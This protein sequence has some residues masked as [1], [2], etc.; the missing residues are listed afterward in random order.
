MSYNAIT[1]SAA[2]KSDI[3]EVAS[4]CSQKV[5]TNYVMN[6]NG[7]YGI[8]VVEHRERLMC[9]NSRNVFQYKAA[10]EIG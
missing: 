9:Q 1:E 7:E 10:Q 8:S 2:L 4:F 5:R 3:K 6:T